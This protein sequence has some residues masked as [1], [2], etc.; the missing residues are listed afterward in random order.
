MRHYPDLF[1]M[2]P[3]QSLFLAKKKRDENA[4]CGSIPCCSVTMKQ[5]RKKNSRIFS[6]PMQF[7]EYR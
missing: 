6:I 4:Y 3:E 2:T 7:R 1:H 5:G